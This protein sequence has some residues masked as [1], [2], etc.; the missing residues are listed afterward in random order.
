[1]ELMPL[2]CL[3]PLILLS[4]CIESPEYSPALPDFDSNE[5][6]IA[7][8]TEEAPAKD[9]NEF[10]AED[11]NEFSREETEQ[12]EI[13]PQIDLR[14]NKEIFYPSE[15]DSFIVPGRFKYKDRNFILQFDKIIKKGFNR[16]EAR[17]NL[18]DLNWNLIDY[19]VIPEQQE[20]EFHDKDDSLIQL[21]AFI[22]FAYV[23]LPPG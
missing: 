9:L 21:G 7:P 5:L 2:P 10:G 19:T 1:M 6:A 23:M 18:Y 20:V 15:G 8:P 11:L 14:I 13:K 17:F 3:L 16:Y 4:G 12:E 22:Y